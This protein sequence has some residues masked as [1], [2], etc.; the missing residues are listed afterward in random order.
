M[1]TEDALE[2]ER[3]L[4]ELKEHRH[5]VRTSGRRQRGAAQKYCLMPHRMAAIKKTKEKKRR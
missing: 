2:N 5:M 4:E 3:L 1:G